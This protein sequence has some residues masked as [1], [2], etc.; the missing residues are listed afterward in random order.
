MPIPTLKC[1]AWLP[2]PLNLDSV[3]IVME[4]LTNGGAFSFVTKTIN[5]VL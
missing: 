4:G 1:Q 5:G 2:L 3:L